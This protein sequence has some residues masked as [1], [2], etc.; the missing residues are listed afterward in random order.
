MFL[1]VQN[2]PQ[3]PA[4]T[5]AQ[6][7]TDSGHP[8]VSIAAFDDQS[9]PEPSRL[10]GV[11]ILGGD[12]SVHQTE[13]Y[14]YLAKVRGFMERCLASNT[15][16]LGICLGGQLL[17]QVA[18]G[19]VASPSPHGEKGINLVRL[20]EAGSRDLLFAGVPDPFTTFQLHNDSF[21]PPADATLLASSEACPAQ[22]FRL[23][24][25]AYGLQFHPEV[26]QTIVT[27]WGEMTRP[28]VDLVPDFLRSKTDFDHAS[29]AI[30]SNFISLAVLRSLP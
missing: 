9:F 13:S 19:T 5:I 17:A 4:G 8:Y 24:D 14:P 1:L 11:I 28:Q 2:D 22:A 29:Q 18:G 7:L 3:C 16:L 6:L 21:T 30:L 26:D 10:T 27:C 23:G 12:M 20:N 15:P 25:C